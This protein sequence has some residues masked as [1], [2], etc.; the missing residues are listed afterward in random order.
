VPDATITTLHEL[1]PLL[2]GWFPG[3]RNGHGR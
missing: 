1:L 3:W 2:D